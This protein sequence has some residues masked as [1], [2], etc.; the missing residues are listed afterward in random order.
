M[1]TYLQKFAFALALLGIM[2]AGA[3]V[4]QNGEG[5]REWRQGPPS[6]ED[7]LARMSDTLD[8][9]DQQAVELLVVLQE[10][11]EQRAALH[12]ESM[13]TIGPEICA[14]KAAAEE[15]ILAILTPEQTEQFLEMKEARKAKAGERNRGRGPRGPD[16]SQYET[17]S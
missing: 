16:C 12:E 14:Q 7:V 4:A 3:A 5:G 15:D 2:T 10:H 8:L 11:A 17:E 9:T 1:K 6:V 13:A